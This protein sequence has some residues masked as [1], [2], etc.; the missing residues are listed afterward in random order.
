MK[1]LQSKKAEIGVETLFLILMGILF[2]GI[3][4]FGFTKFFDVEDNLS[5]QEKQEI[6][7][8]IKTSFEYCEDPLNKGNFKTFEIKNNEFNIICL[9]GEDI[10]QTTN[11][12][13]QY[14]DLVQLYENDENVILIDGSFKLIQDDNNN[15]YQFTNY[16]IVDSIKL[17]SKLQ[18]TKCYIE[19]DKKNLIEVKIF[20][21]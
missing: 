3:L 17:N 18:E 2:I 20:C 13:N 14:T 19:D 21:E 10:L 9:I 1:I 11:Q 15:K 8:Y 5:E 12:Y 7:Q 6:K 4:V 16:Y